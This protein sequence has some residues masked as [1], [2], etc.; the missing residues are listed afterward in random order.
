MFFT[1]PVDKHYYLRVNDM[2]CCLFENHVT[3]PA[4]EMLLVDIKPRPT[5]RRTLVH[6][7]SVFRVFE[8][9]CVSASTK[10]IRYTVVG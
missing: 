9:A 6:I 4:L 10:K 8:D 5:S 7:Y 3:L 1:F 2:L